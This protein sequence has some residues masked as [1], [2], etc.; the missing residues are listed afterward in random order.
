MLSAASSDIV[1]AMK[2]NRNAYS[3]SAG[4]LLAQ[5]A[6]LL[7]V[8]PARADTVNVAVASNF[9]PAMKPLSTRFEALT[10]H[11]LRIS[12]ASTGK[13][14]AQVLNGAPFDVLLSADSERP[15]LLTSS[16]RASPESR[17]TYAIGRLVL[18]SRDPGVSTSN[19]LEALGR[20]DAGRVAIANPVTAPYGAAAKET[21]LKLGTWEGL[22]GR[23][24]VGENIGQALHFVA[25][26]NARFGF[27]AAA[28]INATA[29]PEASCT[30]YVPPAYHRAIEQQA[31]LLARA[32][33][34]PQAKV[35]LEFLR[36]PDAR[37]I[38]AGQ[39]YG[40][41]DRAGH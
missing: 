38:I 5:A 39:G 20:D 29:L 41:P 2:G 11:T 24:V 21:L 6:L 25:S 16:G 32:A 3:L 26:G 15:I 4:L 40:V 23:I 1:S 33:D 27:I 10:G 36:S 30:W 37:R 19:C 34:K 9:L 13:L 17:F 8:G 14:Y 35:F 12:G 18:W 28:Q 31:V 22:R 7:L